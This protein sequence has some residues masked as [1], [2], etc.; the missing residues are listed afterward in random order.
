[1]PGLQPIVDIAA[2][3]LTITRSFHAALFGTLVVLGS[4]VVAPLP[5][6]YPPPYTPSYGYV[7]Y[8]PSPYYAGYP[9]YFGPEIG[10]GVGVGRGW[11]GGGRGGGGRHGRR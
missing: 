1:M 2:H 8:E 9:W 3:P 4:C 10:I 6:A 11:R 5:E 7:P